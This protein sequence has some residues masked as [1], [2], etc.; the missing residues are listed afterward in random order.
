MC[1]T[2]NVINL[3]VSFIWVHSLNPLFLRKKLTY[4]KK[5]RALV[6]CS[7]KK[8]MKWY[9]KRSWY[10]SGKILC[11]WFWTMLA[12]LHHCIVFWN[13][14]FYDLFFLLFVRPTRYCKKDPFFIQVS[15]QC[16]SCECQKGQDE[17][18]CEMGEY[19]ERV[20]WNKTRRWY[21]ALCYGLLVKLKT[22]YI[23]IKGKYLQ[24]HDVLLRDGGNFNFEKLR[25]L[26]AGQ[27]HMGGQW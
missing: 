18:L 8:G 9:K 25:S 10:M 19:K 16:M 14:E 7:L 22:M 4:R 5:R 17:T 27:V 23:Y 3:N 1:S 26:G 21:P 20:G 15:L 13:D 12:F 24:L 2:G 6:V 11:N